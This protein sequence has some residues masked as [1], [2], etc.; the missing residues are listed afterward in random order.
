MH[1]MGLLLC[2]LGAPS[3]QV[4]NREGVSKGTA[5]IQDSTAQ[6]TRRGCWCPT[7]RQMDTSMNPAQDQYSSCFQ[8]E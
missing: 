7:G 4:L 1:G 8:W 3:P 5:R 2:Y 6:Q